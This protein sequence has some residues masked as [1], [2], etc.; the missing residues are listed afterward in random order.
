MWIH[1]PRCQI[2][3]V[4]IWRNLNAT[5][6]KNRIIHLIHDGSS[7]H[8]I[9]TMAYRLDHQQKSHL[10]QMLDGRQ[11]HIDIHFLNRRNRWNSHEVAHVHNDMSLHRPNRIWK[12]WNL[13]VSSS[14]DRKWHAIIF[15][16]S[17]RHWASDKCYQPLWSSIFV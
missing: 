7:E 8:Q 11:R 1:R 9:L 17:N 6:K 15:T 14:I 2:K 3:S 13:T 10:V 5:W 12:K 4:V 16:S